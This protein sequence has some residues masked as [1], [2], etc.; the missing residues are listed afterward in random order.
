MAVDL[1]LEAR[2]G[3][4]MATWGISVLV[5]KGVAIATGAEVFEC[6]DNTVDGDLKTATLACFCPGLPTSQED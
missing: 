5:V 3:V 1:D 2:I 4:A 6:L